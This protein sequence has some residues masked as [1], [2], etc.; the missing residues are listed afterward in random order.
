MAWIELHDTLPGNKK[1]Y[2]LM[3]ALRVDKH[4]A[5]GVVTC[6][7]LWALRQ[8]TD[9]DISGCSPAAIADAIGWRKSAKGLYE[10]LC[11]SGWIDRS[12]DGTARIHDWDE[13][14]WRYFDKVKVTREQTRKRVTKY[15]E[16]KKSNA[17]SNACNALQT[18]QSNDCNTPTITNTLTNT[19]YIDDDNK[20]MVKGGTEALH[21]GGDDPGDKDQDDDRGEP[22]KA[23]ERMAAAVK[24]WENCGFGPLSGRAAEHIG[25]WLDDYGLEWTLEALRR[26][27][28]RGKRSIGYVNGILQRWHADGGMDSPKPPPGKQSG[29]YK[30]VAGEQYIQQDYTPDQLDSVIRKLE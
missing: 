6:L 25:H 13:Y 2:A 20:A 8:A 1:I 18:L 19:V 5:I 15:R 7:W 21:S 10:A 23:D 27:G 9:G 16:R 12:E 30:P 22:G 29:G 24:E 4:K 14:T 3:E 17:E 28:D 26:A 11:A